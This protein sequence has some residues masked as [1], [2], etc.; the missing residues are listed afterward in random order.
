MARLDADTCCC[1]LCVARRNVV[2]LTLAQ[3][4]L[5]AVRP[6]RSI[7]LHDYDTAV[8]A[9]AHALDHQGRRSAYDE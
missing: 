2:A 3:V 7:H 1:G 8:A 6:T 5:T 9:V 4:A